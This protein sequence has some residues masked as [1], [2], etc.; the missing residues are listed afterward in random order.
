M[1]SFLDL[2][3]SCRKR[4]TRDLDVGNTLACTF[5]TQTCHA[6]HIPA[7][8]FERASMA[9]ERVTALHGLRVSVLESGIAVRMNHLPI[10]YMP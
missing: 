4:S 5:K 10:G 2:G 1:L 6:D 8:R 3:D 9:C 7:G